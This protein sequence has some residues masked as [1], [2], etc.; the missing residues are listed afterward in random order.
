ME[1]L[2]SIPSCSFRFTRAHSLAW[3]SIGVKGEGEA[4]WMPGKRWE[5]SPPFSPPPHHAPSALGKYSPLRPQDSGGGTLHPLQPG[6]GGGADAQ[7]PVTDPVGGERVLPGHPRHD[8]PARPDHRAH[9]QGKG[10][11]SFPLLPNKSSPAPPPN[12]PSPAQPLPH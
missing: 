5:G 4:G 6:A 2:E 7:A 12:P 10:A 8:L 1:K 3:L 11:R 9:Q